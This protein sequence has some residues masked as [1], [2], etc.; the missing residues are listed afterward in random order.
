MYLMAC[1]TKPLLIGNFSLD[2]GQIGVRNDPLK[3]RNLWVAFS[4][5]QW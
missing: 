4:M 1:L 3:Y 5:L 2:A